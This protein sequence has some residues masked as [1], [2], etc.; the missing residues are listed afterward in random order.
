MAILLSDLAESLSARLEGDAKVEI[1]GAAEPAM[2]GPQDLAMALKPAFAE[3]LRDG[4]AR[5]AILWDGADWRSYGLEAALFVPRPRYAM[6]GVTKALDPGPEIAPGIHPTAVVDP[7]AR[8]GDGAAIGP[9]VI[10]GRD[11]RI[12]NRVR[13]AGHASVAENVTLGDDVLLHSGVRIERGVTIGHRFIAQ[14]NVVVGGDG[15]SFV[16][17]EKSAVE[18]VRE[19]LG[20]NS[21]AGE[22]SWTRIHSLGAVDIGDDVEMGANS[23]VDRGTIRSTRIGRGT[24]LDNLVQVGHNTVIGEDCLLCGLVGIAGSTVIGDRVVLAG[25]VGVSDN[26]VI[27]DDVVAGG[28]TK[29]FS[30]VPKGRVILGSPAVEMATQMEINKG[31]RRLPR[32]YRDVAALKKAVQNPGET[33]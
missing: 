31:M 20:E 3:G 30:R 13:I 9:F 12:G 14:A 23:C 26:I 16:T 8:I 27:G 10:I 24:K 5:A 15:F 19:S 7:S 25:Q 32:L 4:A 1:S 21:N 22:Q 29:I 6:A 28:A 33:D 17:P 11:A 2:A 18:N